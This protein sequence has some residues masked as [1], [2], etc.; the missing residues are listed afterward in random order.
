[1]PSTLN[2]VSDDVIFLLKKLLFSWENWDLYKDY[3]LNQ[4]LPEYISNLDKKNDRD[5]IILKQ[6]KCR[7]KSEEWERLIEIAKDIIDSHLI[8]EIAIP[9]IQIFLEELDFIEA[10]KYVSGINNAEITRQFHNIK[11]LVINKQFEDIFNFIS[12]SNFLEASN[13]FSRIEKYATQDQVKQYF[14][15][16]RS[17]KISQIN[18]FLERYKF[19]EAH[20]V[21]QE[22]I[23]NFSESEYRI[24]EKIYKTILAKKEIISSITKL[25]NSKDFSSADELFRTSFL[26]DQEEYLQI[27]IP[28]QNRMFR[29]KFVSL[30]THGM[31]DEQAYAIAN[32]T[33]NLLVRARAGSGKTSTLTNKAL[34]LIDLYQINKDEILLLA[35]N[36]DA[37]NEIKKRITQLT[38]DS[39]F[40]TARTFHSLACRLAKPSN[41]ILFDKKG[42][43]DYEDSDTDEVLTRYVQE[44]VL[45]RIKEGNFLKELYKYFQKEVTEIEMRGLLQEEQQQYNFL[46]ETP[47]TS[48][49]GETVNSTIEKYIADYLFEH[50]IPYQYLKT[51]FIKEQAYQPSFSIFYDD[52]KYIIECKDLENINY[53]SA[54]EIIESERHYYYLQKDFTLIEITS[55]G[56]KVSRPNFEIILQS[57]LKEVGLNQEKLSD[58]ALMEKFTRFQTPTKIARIFTQFIQRAKKQI[59]YPEDII[60][61]LEHYNPGSEKENLFLHIALQVY[62]EYQ[63]KLIRDHMVDFDDILIHAANL[64][65]ET[66]G[67][68]SFSVGDGSAKRT[69]AVNSL[70]WILIDEFQDFSPLFFNIISKIKKYNPTVRFFCVGD[71][72]QSINGFAGSDLKYFNDFQKWIPDSQTNELLLNFRSELQIVENANALMDGLGKGGKSLPGKHSGKINSQYLDDIKIHLEIKTDEPQ[73]DDS[74]FFV[75]EKDRNGFAKKSV[76]LLASKYIKACYE[77]IQKE[78]ALQR[79]DGKEKTAM[80]LSRKR[81]IKDIPIYDFSNHLNN[82]LFTDRRELEKNKNRVKTLTT[83]TSKG[84]EADIVIVLDASKKS[85]PLIHPDNVLFRIFGNTIADVIEEEKRLFYVALTRAKSSLYIITEK[86]IESPFLIYLLAFSECRSKFNNEI[87]AKVNREEEINRQY[88]KYYFAKHD[89]QGYYDWLMNQEI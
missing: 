26:V 70:R 9:K 61:M 51:I 25:L 75:Y 85:Y 7:A 24:Q 73:N 17:K 62:I 65:D 82:L 11:S 31:T 30:Q 47:Q 29:K 78:F 88:D 45:A 23:E 60:K 34:S 89:P 66:E 63:K 64:I 57:K 69:I 41:T 21:F 19:D 16:I 56:Q 36:K 38:R 59:L 12:K 54:Q 72:W 14:L 18:D 39:T 6:I 43:Y 81:N 15:L 83:H 79:I 86:G 42:G 27:K 35:F 55:E 76:N 4:L 71:D 8:A 52:K 40:D 33:R 3:Y 50:D 5:G 77:I 10:E 53:E 1:M 74:K 2:L 48:L 22:G 84:L 49:R 87:L 44:I 13:Q 46:R 58:Q 68:C 28:V 32:P 80:I 37:A 67:R 20:E